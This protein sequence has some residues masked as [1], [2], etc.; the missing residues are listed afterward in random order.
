MAPGDAESP[1]RRN[2]QLVRL[3]P[4]HGL[5]ARA[6][7]RKQGRLMRGVDGFLFSVFRNALRLFATPLG[8][9]ALR[10][11]DRSSCVRVM[12]RLE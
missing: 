6:G 2:F 3:S 1:I 12:K 11:P 8:G 5:T 9:R 7:L 10:P 4:G